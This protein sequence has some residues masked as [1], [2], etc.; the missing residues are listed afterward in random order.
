M[1]NTYSYLAAFT[2]AAILLNLSPGPSL[3]F[4]S[5]R[6]VQ[7]GKAA[8]AISALGLATGSSIHAVLAGVGVT[9][10]IASSEMI[11]QAV[12]LVGGSYIIYLGSNGFLSSKPNSAFTAT[13]DFSSD[14]NESL[15]KIYFQSLMVEFLNPKTVLFYFSILPGLLAAKDYTLI[16]AIAI[17][18][19][20]PAT[21]LPIDLF[22]GISGG[23]LAK[24][25]SSLPRVSKVLDGLSSLALISIG[26]YL[27]YTNLLV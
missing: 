20:V 21:A 18:L 19:I 8:G 22:A 15:R 27:I 3:I 2:F 7:Q 24:S 9:A 1:E 4:V 12:A 10:I 11:A 5:A 14:R 13:Q 26:L 6:G 23:Y 17:S 25:T 16:Q